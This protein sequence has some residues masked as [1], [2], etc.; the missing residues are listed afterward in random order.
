MME[1]NDYELMYYQE[2]YYVVALLDELVRLNNS[3][4]NLEL[5]ANGLQ[6]VNQSLLE[7]KNILQKEVEKLRAEYEE[8]SVSVA[9]DE[10]R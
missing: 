5:S 3:Y 8:S 1:E 9:E 2:H 4:K 10:N 6:R 7:Q